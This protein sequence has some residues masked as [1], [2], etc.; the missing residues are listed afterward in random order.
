[1]RH[2]AL[3]A[4]ERQHLADQGTA[5]FRGVSNALQIVAQGIV[6]TSPCTFLCHTGVP[7]NAGQD[8]VEI[9]RNAASEMTDCLHLL[10]LAELGLELPSFPFRRF[11]RVTCVV[12]FQLGTSARCKDAEHR[13]REA[14]ARQLT[15]AHDRHHSA[16]AIQRV[17]KRDRRA[18]LGTHDPKMRMGKMLLHIS[19]DVADSLSGNVLTWC[20]FKLVQESL[21]KPCVGSEAK[22]PRVTRS[23]W[24]E[25]GDERTLRRKYFRC[26]LSEAAEDVV[27]AA[28]S[29]TSEPRQDAERRVLR[30]DNPS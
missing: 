4:A 21:S 15:A 7:D 23:V 28:D 1:M 5:P 22:N 25:L 26:H 19:W 14:F 13:L 30:L 12:S 10:C 17:E 2:T 6:G 29:G 8:V 9:M 20:A 11:D 18:G 24:Q 16:G 3:S 27:A